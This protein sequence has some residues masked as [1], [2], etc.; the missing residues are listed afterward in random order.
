MLKNI[1]KI[2]VFLLKIKDNF[3]EWFYPRYV[4]WSQ[5]NLPY[6]HS[7]SGTYLYR[8]LQTFNRIFT[9]P[10][11]VLFVRISKKNPKIKKEMT[12]SG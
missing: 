12:S 10:P 4:S 1:Q 9:Q 11:V 3:R 5:W 6:I 2:N 8:L 7:I